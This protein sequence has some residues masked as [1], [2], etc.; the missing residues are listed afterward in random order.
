MVR[1]PNWPTT[2]RSASTRLPWEG[3]PYQRKSTV[4]PSEGSSTSEG[5]GEIQSTF[6][7]SES[8]SKPEV[9]GGTESNDEGSATSE[10]RGEIQ[11]TATPSNG[12][13]S[14]KTTR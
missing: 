1:E 13:F 10:G 5:P 14:S 11:S 8:F 2:A 6:T 7:Q 12:S 3:S 4:T 9:P